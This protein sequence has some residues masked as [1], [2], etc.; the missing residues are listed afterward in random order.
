MQLFENKNKPVGKA[1]RILK[2]MIKVNQNNY[3]L[4]F[5]SD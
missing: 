1:N 3:K 4:E 5:F 2:L